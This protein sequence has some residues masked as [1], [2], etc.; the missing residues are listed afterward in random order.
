M[1]AANSTTRRSRNIVVAADLI[2]VERYAWRHHESA[3]NSCVVLMGDNGSENR[4]SFFG[5]F[6]LHVTHVTQLTLARPFLS[7]TTGGH[8]CSCGLRECPEATCQSGIAA[9]FSAS[10]W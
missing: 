5:Q 6:F 2:A 3:A 9:P 1:S 7:S 4:L 8:S 10:L